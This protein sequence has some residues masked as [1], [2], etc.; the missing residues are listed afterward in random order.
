MGENPCLEL[1]YKAISWFSIQLNLKTDFFLFKF[2]KLFI[3]IPLLISLMT[4]EGK[5][6]T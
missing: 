2:S 6:A 4:R 5:F 3:L 1:L